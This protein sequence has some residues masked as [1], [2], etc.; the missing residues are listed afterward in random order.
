MYGQ[1]WCVDDSGDLWD[2]YGA[3]SSDWWRGRGGTVCVGAECV[4]IVHGDEFLGADNYVPDVGRQRSDRSRL[5]PG[6]YS[7]LDVAG[8]LHVEL[9]IYLY[10]E[11]VDG[12]YRRLG[13]VFDNGSA[14]GWYDGRQHVC[15]CDECDTDIH[16]QNSADDYVPS[17][18]RQRID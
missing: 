16:C 13:D 7:Q 5:Q 15:G 8:E 10:G 1:W 14:G 4:A 17:I 11:W 3:R 18:G 9:I 6:C 12:E 2:V